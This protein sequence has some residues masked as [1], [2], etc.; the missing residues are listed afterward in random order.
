MEPPTGRTWMAEGKRARFE[1]GQLKTCT[2]R[3]LGATGIEGGH[4]GCKNENIM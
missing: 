1:R 2:A 4:L 3:I